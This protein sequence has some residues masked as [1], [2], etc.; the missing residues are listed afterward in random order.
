M[1]YALLILVFMFCVA[2]SALAQFSVRNGLRDSLQYYERNLMD[3]DKNVA[4]RA[5]RA[6][7]LHYTVNNKN[8]ALLYAYKMLDNSTN[9]FFRAISY[10]T[11]GD[12][13]Y[14]AGEARNSIINYDKAVDEFRLAKNQ[15]GIVGVLQ[16]MSDL[17]L[18]RSLFSQAMEKLFLAEFI[19]NEEGD[20]Y[21]LAQNDRKIA[22]V[23]MLSE[24]IELAADYLA[25][26]LKIFFSL[27][28]FRR[29][30]KVVMAYVEVLS[31]LDSSENSIMY[32]NRLAELLPEGASNEDQALLFNA[33]GCHYTFSPKLDSAIYYFQKALSL[34]D[35]NNL[36]EH[37]DMLSRLAHVYSLKGDWENTIKTNIK[38]LYFR[39]KYGSVDAIVSTWNNIT[40]DYFQNDDFL[41]GRKMLDSAWYY[42]NKTE[43]KSFYYPYLLEKEIA[44][45][46]RQNLY[47]S[48]LKYSRLLTDFQKERLHNK[49]GYDAGLLRY[50]LTQRKNYRSYDPGQNQGINRFFIIF[51]I[52]ALLLSIGAVFFLLWHLNKKSASFIDLR[53]NILKLKADL[54]RNKL[55]MR[56]KDKK[57]DYHLNIIQKLPLAAVCLEDDFQISYMN[58]KFMEITGMNYRE[59][60]SMDFFRFVSIDDID[61]FQKYLEQF[62]ANKFKMPHL[63]FGLK[64]KDGTERRFIASTSKLVAADKNEF[65]LVFY[66]PTY[67][68]LALKAFRD[69]RDSSRKEL[70]DTINL[71]NYVHHKLMERLIV[72]SSDTDLSVNNL[73]LEYRF[74]Y[75][76]LSSYTK[77]LDANYSLSLEM[78][79]LQDISGA[80]KSQLLAL[81]DINLEWTYS[82][83]SSHEIDS[84]CFFTDRQMLLICLQTILQYFWE[85]GTSEILIDV[86]EENEKL[87][88]SIS[89]NTK[90]DNFLGNFDDLKPENHPL[91]SLIFYLGRRLGEQIR[92]IP[93]KSAAFYL[94][95]GLKPQNF[96]QERKSVKET[97]ASY[98]NWQGKSILIAEDVPENYRLLATHINRTGAQHAYAEDGIRAVEILSSG[99]KF[100]LIL[101][102][103]QMPGLNGLETF[104]VL[105]ILGI[106]I[107]VVAITAYAHGNESQFIK[108]MGFDAYISKPFSAEDLY[109]RLN[110]FL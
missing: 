43:G 63:N 35:T 92:F 19:L 74:Y 62:D 4:F 84:V 37:S 21:L 69:S 33:F 77:I 47:D 42:E 79:H 56:E 12:V 102:D 24:N 30:S 58:S 105:K 76:L 52:L 23:A 78:M 5:N 26:A 110:A 1:R 16:K 71:L 80:M 66:D 40:G 50:E 90:V 103:I 8:L 9:S 94:S 44:Y 85:C 36:I 98:P 86:Y 38:A 83:Q 51:L 14:A 64:R 49:A 106:K 67:Y 17:Y 97:G 34:S 89:S 59:L 27:H 29:A 22:R 10:E 95:I 61:P 73:T 96:I 46:S 65:L 57:I 88:L 3:I 45:F 13:Y 87:H 53:E 15:K 75:F 101:M 81:P 70:N 2:G 7:A 48:I 28:D 31:H 104:S 100:D 11:I 72:N 108:E 39:K 55:V 82:K 20:D 109:A 68:D 18:H 93:G 41:S 99:K 54:A 107:P 6:F 25:S 32:V 91:M 60:I